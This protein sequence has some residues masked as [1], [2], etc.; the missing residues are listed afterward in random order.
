MFDGLYGSGS[1]ITRWAKQ[2]IAREQASP[3]AIPPAMRILY[4]PGTGT[5][6]N[7]E[8]IARA[9][10]PDLRAGSALARS[11]RVDGTRV[12]HDAIPGRFGPALL[13]DAGADL[14]EAR[15]FN[16]T[17]ELEGSLSE[18]YETPPSEAVSEHL[19]WFDPAGEE[20]GA[21]WT[22]GESY[23]ESSG[24]YPVAESSFELP[25]TEGPY[26]EMPTGESTYE[27][28]YSESAYEGPYSESTYGEAEV[29]EQPY[30]EATLGEQ[31]LAEAGSSEA[32]VSMEW[33]E[34]GAIAE[35]QEAGEG[36]L[37]EWQ[38]S[39]EGPLGEELDIPGEDLE[40]GPWSGAEASTETA[41]DAWGEGP[42][43]AEWNSLMGDTFAT[44]AGDRPVLE[45]LL[46]SEVGAG[47][48]LA[49]RLK[50]VAAFVLGGTLRRGDSGAGVAAL[51][52][53]LGALGIDVAV[54]GSFGAHTE[55]A[56]RA[57]QA[58][59]SIT[60]DGV[61]GPLT[62][63][64]IA[65]ALSSGAPSDPVPGPP[66]P[67]PARP[68]TGA[69]RAAG[70]VRQSPASTPC[71]GDWQ[72]GARAL[73]AQWT[74]LTGRKAGGYV[75]RP[76]RGSQQP[77][78][79]GDGRAIDAYANAN[80]PAQR[81]QAE[82]YA[83]WL[84]ANAVEL[85]C[86]YI[87]WNGR[88]WS[89]PRRAEGWRPY[90]GV[91]THTDH[92]H[93]EVSWEGARQPSGLFSGGVPGLGS[94]TPAPPGPVPPAPVPP[95]PVPP[96]GQRLAP[97]VFVATYG[98]AARAS[99]ATSGVPALVTLGQAALESGW[100]QKAP[101][102]NFFGIKAKTSDPDHRCQLLVTREVYRDGNRKL[103]NI[104]SIKQR[105][106][107]KFDYM[108]RAWFRAYPDVKAA[109]DDHARVLR[110]PRYANAF[111]VANEPYAFATE[112]AR[113]GYATDP[114]YASVLHG[115]MRTIE[116]AGGP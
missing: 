28:P 8:A 112:V 9:L 104:I 13:A 94:G 30:G 46:E 62:K 72:P 25:S 63:A 78:V 48:G 115:V 73:A 79:H 50:S 70:I 51:Q 54:D 108:V 41:L 86:A 1:N 113:G 102:F 68:S 39:G 65:A 44:E 95:G 24:E 34:A 33:G 107:G 66:S 14:S 83:A 114:S 98:P 35:W 60:E 59:R 106:D 64:A 87:I 61:V 11:F 84:I 4:R 55:R 17:S 22:T 116:G 5:Q 109:F 6:A 103:P 38:E 10:R 52:R 16:E 53:A 92:L 88:Q 23:L 89:W 36:P 29:Q 47:T 90:H 81:A 77:S 105:P 32:A 20:F 21:Q 85:Q 12:A 2:R 31:L 91:S 67:T 18:S 111:T 93:I 56:V 58:R 80:D 75:C 97:R 7:S 26:A 3:S 37:G 42:S 71:A 69:D 40:A 43:E 27:G 74:R 57:F 15:T 45:A 82:I 99:Q 100:G 76:I 49:D 19:E 101:R 110:L 96:A